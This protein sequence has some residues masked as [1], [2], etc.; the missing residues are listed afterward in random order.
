MKNV[1]VKTNRL[2]A[3]LQTL[4]L[5]ETRII[6]LCI[7]D[8]RETGCGLDASKPL[9]VDAGRYAAAFGVSLDAG[10]KR[11]LEAEDGLFKRQF[12]IAD[13]TGKV[14]KSRWIQD[15]SYLREQG[16]IEMT[17]TRI[18]VD[19]ISKIDG[20][21]QF[22]T[23]YLLEQTANLT[24]VYAVRLYELLM[25]WKTTSKTPVF[26]LNQ[27]REQLGVGANE[28]KLMN[29]FK[30]R[31]LDLATSQINEHTDI[32]ASYEQHKRGRTII[33]F[34]F[35]FKEKKQVIEHKA[36]IKSNSL[37]PLK[38]VTDL[39]AFYKKHRLGV[40]SMDETFKRL[41]KEAAEGTFSMTLTD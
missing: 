6:Q 23:S 32:T 40:E 17:F 8:A 21:E 29:D 1:V 19:Q 37:N 33:G 4:T 41:R 34:S 26:E 25:Q 3:A 11:M 27:F 24:S 35:K 31:V 2:I 30:K 18:V 36:S 13:E 12:T 20:I 14:I 7:I 28:Y 38:G 9:R 10:Y 22:F 16:A 5:A 15:V 39:D